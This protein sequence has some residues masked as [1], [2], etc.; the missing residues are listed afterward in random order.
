MS[1]TLNPQL[2]GPIE[3]TAVKPD[4]GNQ[5]LTKR[6]RD[7]E[8]QIETTN[9]KMDRWAQII[10]GRLQ[11]LTQSQKNVT[12]QIKYVTD[13]FNKQL[14][15][16]HSKINERKTADVKTQELFDR[17]NQIV[18]SFENRVGQLQ[19]IVGEQEMKLMSYQA[20]YDEILR[21]IRSLKGR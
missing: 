4:A 18:H 10:D 5:Q 17:H 15:H 7:L 3:T 14:A 21:E 9:G 19:K 8:A 1:R 6:L 16:L 11:Q 20:T 12:E 2:F 13:S